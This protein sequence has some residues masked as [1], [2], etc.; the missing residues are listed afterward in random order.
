MEHRPTLE[1]YYSLSANEVIRCLYGARS[2]ITV[3]TGVRHW[4]L[5]ELVEY[6]SRFSGAGNVFK[7]NIKVLTNLFLPYFPKMKLGLSIT[8]LSVSPPL[9]IFEPRGR[10]HEI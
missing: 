3:V 5:S 1:H 4:I 6:I 7:F 9:I 2:F 10:F 8:S